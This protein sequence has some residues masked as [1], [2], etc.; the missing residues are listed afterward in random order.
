MVWNK[1]AVKEWENISA[2]LFAA[3]TIQLVDAVK[4]FGQTEYT[5]GWLYALDKAHNRAVANLILAK[6]G[7]RRSLDS[8]AV[9]E[10]IARI[11]KS[12]ERNGNEDFVRGMRDSLTRVM[13]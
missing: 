3:H 10:F 6:A 4:T 1:G 9:N 13:S 2:S 11:I 5:A 7:L 8:N 12:A